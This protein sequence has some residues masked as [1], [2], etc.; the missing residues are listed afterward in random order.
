V[1]ITS[2]L[3]DP[4]T[5]T[6]ANNAVVFAMGS[7]LKSGVAS[8][9]FHAV[10]FAA[11]AQLSTANVNTANVAT[12]TQSVINQKG[13][14]LVAH[15]AIGEFC[16]VDGVPG[17]Q[18]AWPPKGAAGILTDLTAA[19]VSGTKLASDTF[20]S[21]GIWS[22]TTFTAVTTT[23]TPPSASLSSGNDA[24]GVPLY[25]LECQPG[26]STQVVQGMTVGDFRFKCDVTLNPGPYRIDHNPV[27]NNDSA[28]AEA[29]AT[30]IG[31][32]KA[33]RK[34][35]MLAFV[36]GAAVD[37][38]PTATGTPHWSGL[39]V[40]AAKYEFLDSV[41]VQFPNG[42]L[43]Q[44]ANTVFQVF[45]VATIFPE[46]SN[47]PAW[48]ADVKAILVTFDVGRDV[49]SDDTMQLFWDPSLGF[50]SDPST[51]DTGGSTTGATTKA[52]ASASYISSV[53]VAIAALVLM[54]L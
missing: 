52:S 4:S 30:K 31:C 44:T 9:P 23:T 13:F 2:W 6:G 54:S 3:N 27:F 41:D 20:V 25:T 38:T 15:Y 1:W 45:D 39:A 37:A 35:A 48:I 53:I 29:T 7:E 17:Y 36:A 5:N 21:G 12:N 8:P 50:D 51:L 47:L 14:V 19:V 11:G 10:G 26:N 32:S 40:G 33:N 42:T 49:M 22:E 24:G 46:R 34:M 18:G 28:S 16:D 43:V